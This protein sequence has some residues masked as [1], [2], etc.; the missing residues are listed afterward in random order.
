MAKWQD[1]DGTSYILILLK[2]C[3]QTF[4]TYTIAVCTVRNSWW[5]TKE[6]SETFDFHSKIIFEKISA[7]SWFYYKFSLRFRVVLKIKIFTIINIDLLSYLIGLYWRWVMLTFRHRG[8]CIRVLGQAFR[9]SPE[10]A[11]YIFNQQIYFIIWYLLDRVSL[12]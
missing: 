1:Q 6:F 3:L 5:W 4:M 12:I 7:S 10:N 11:F 9:Y 2:S 8:S